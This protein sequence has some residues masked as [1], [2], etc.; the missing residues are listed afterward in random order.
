LVSIGEKAFNNCNSLIDI[1]LPESIEK[2]ESNAF[3]GCNKLPFKVQ[4]GLRKLGYR[5]SF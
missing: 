5:G 1:E 3:L 4:A 2:I